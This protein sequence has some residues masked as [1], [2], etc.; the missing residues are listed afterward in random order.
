[1]K[2]DIL[3]KR[4]KKIASKKSENFFKMKST[5][6]YPA[7]FTEERKENGDFWGYCIDFPGLQGCFTQGE[8]IEDGMIMAED[9]L[10]LTLYDYED[11][12]E[13]IPKPFKIEDIKVKKGEFVTYIRCDTMEY[14]KKFSKKAV[15]KTLTI[16]E[17]LNKEAM[18][19]GVN[20]SQV[21]QKALLKEIEK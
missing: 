6:V 17:W 11:T 15:K 9:V 7:I 16:P 20:F 19:M 1:M 14:R 5:Y 18:K 12:G 4:N 13:D 21:L 8:D 10:A 2:M 3:K